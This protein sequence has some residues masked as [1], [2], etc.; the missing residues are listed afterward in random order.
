MNGTEVWTNF[1]LAYLKNSL[2]TFIRYEV[3]TSKAK[4]KN[5]PKFDKL[6]GATE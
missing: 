3:E 5:Y 4:L 2:G 6:Y 1:L